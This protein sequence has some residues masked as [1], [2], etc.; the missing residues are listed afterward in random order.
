[1]NRLAQRIFIAL[2]ALLLQGGCSVRQLAMNQLGDAL[3]GGGDVFAADNDPDLVGD[4]LPFSLKLMESVLAGTPRHEGLLGALASGFT[5][6]AYG[7]AHLEADFVED[8]DY[9][10]AERLRVRATRLYARARD[11]GLRALGTRREGFAAR[12]RGDP[13]GALAELEASDV[14]ALYWTA[15]AWAGAISLS[16]DN[17]DLVGDL[18]LVED[19]MERALELD[20]DWGMG[21]VHAFFITYEMSRMNAQGDPVENA[22]GYYRRA[23]ELSGGRL[24]SV[25]LAYAESVAVD[26]QDKA[27]FLSLLDKALAIDVDAAPSLRLNNLL[28]Q[29][30]AL[31]LKERLDWYFL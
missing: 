11:Y 14:E 21:A 17:M 30:R 16:L 28:Y 19:M 7:W 24:A 1:M 22:T 2:A 10:E 26:R 6:Y 25:Y 5:Q 29:R 9:S 4:A 15:L 12:L 18:A 13:Q 23:L 20:P 27:L 3:S 8:E 31:W